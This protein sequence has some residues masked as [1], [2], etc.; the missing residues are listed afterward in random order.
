[1]LV[2]LG[3]VRSSPLY[4]EVGSYNILLKD[5]HA[6]PGGCSSSFGTFTS[7]S[8]LLHLVVIIW[9]LLLMALLAVF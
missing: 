8:F 9:Q 2:T 1:M 5:S 7:R 3:K 4:K 6:T